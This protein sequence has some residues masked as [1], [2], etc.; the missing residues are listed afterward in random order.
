M[1]ITPELQTFVDSF[2]ADGNADEAARKSG[3]SVSTA[4]RNASVAQAARDSLAGQLLRLAPKAIRTL[5]RMLDDPRTPAA[6]KRLA[7][8]DI[9]DRIGLVSQTALALSKPLE[10][11]S[12]MPQ[13]ELRALVARLETELFAR[14]KPVR[15]L[16]LSNEPPIPVNP[17]D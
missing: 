14:A 7:A 5:E 1:S 8:S 15:E 4:W 16:E 17:L 13:G 3:V 2:I 11:L 9:L 6:V 10:S 12:E